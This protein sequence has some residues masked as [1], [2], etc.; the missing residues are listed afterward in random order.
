M[1]KLATSSWDDELDSELSDV[2]M[3]VDD[4]LLELSEVTPTSDDELD[5]VADDSSDDALEPDDADV[6]SNSLED[7]L[8]V[9]L[10]DVPVD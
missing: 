9:V 3:R 4:E 1:A 7:E 8:I 2:L 10:D 5:K 6:T